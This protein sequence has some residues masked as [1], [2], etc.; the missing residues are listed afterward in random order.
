MAP[1]FRLAMFDILPVLGELSPLDRSKLVSAANVLQT[2][3]KLGDASWRRLQ[4][5]M[6][7]VEKH[8]IDDFGLRMRTRSTTVENSW[9]ARDQPTMASKP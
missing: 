7:V 4:F 8:E 6:T 1:L 5:A 9:A 3:G 2:R